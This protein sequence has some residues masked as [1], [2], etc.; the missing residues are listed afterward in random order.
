MPRHPF[1]SERDLGEQVGQDQ[2]RQ[3]PLNFHDGCAAQM[4]SHS[5]SPGSMAFAPHNIRDRFMTLATEG[6]QIL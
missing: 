6:D 1:S 2:H 3:R 4:F 5:Y